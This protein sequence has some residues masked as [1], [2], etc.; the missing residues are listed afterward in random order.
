M[1][2]FH[3]QS[4]ELVWTYESLS[5]R[6]AIIIIETIVAWCIRTSAH[7]NSKHI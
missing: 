7:Y 2:Y 4:C 1:N 3:A 6:A 5:E